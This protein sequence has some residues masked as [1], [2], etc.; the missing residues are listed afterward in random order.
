MGVRLGT[1]EGMGVSSPRG[2]L[3]AGFWSGRRVLVTGHTG[4]KGAWLSSWLLK[5]GAEVTGYALAPTDEPNLFELLDLQSRLEHRVADIRDPD[6]LLDAMRR[7]KPEIVV[8]L[9]AQPLVRESYRDPAGTYATNV[10]GT[11]NLLEAVRLSPGPKVVLVVTSDKCYENREWPWGYREIDPLG[12]HDPYSSSKAC[13]ELVTTAYR[14]SYFSGEAGS[15]VVASVRAGNVIGGGDWSVDRVVPD[16]MRAFSAGAPLSV[17][18]PSATRPWQHVLEPLRGYLLLCQLAYERP[19]DAAQPFNIGPGEN[20]VVPVS[21]LMQLISAAWGPD[22]QW[23][24]E[25]SADLHEAGEL[26]LD[27]S[28]ARRL[29]G[30]HPSIGLTEAVDMT[31][32]LYQLFYGGATPAELRAGLE[33]QV[34]RGARAS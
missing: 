20:D 23:T 2:G 15:P 6:G 3:D 12:G 34:D 26:K 31:V 4:F 11:V 14:S 10:M 1:V 9:A 24:V 17:R 28:R 8:H 25:S 21:R 16:A 22:A 19:V 7:V 30:W 18:S 5:L 27:S 29:I 33:S 13:A 32:S